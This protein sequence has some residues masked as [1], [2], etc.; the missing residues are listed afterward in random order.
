M[1]I[2]EVARLA[3]TSVATVSRVFNN[4]E[5]VNPQTRASVQRVARE[6]GYVPNSSARTLRTRRSQ[7]LGVMLP[8]LSN[9]VFAEC[10]Q[11]IAAEAEQ[12][13]YAIV[14][15]T[16]EYDQE[17]ETAAAERLLSAG[18]EALVLVVSNPATSQTLQRT[19]QVGLPYVLAYSQTEEHAC[20]SVDNRQAIYHLVERLHDSGHQRIGMVTGQ[21]HA[22]DRAQ[23]RYKGYLQGMQ[24]RG[25]TA[26]PVWEL[27]FTTQALEQ[28]QQDL[29]QA[30]PPTAL[31][32]SNDLI[33]IR[34]LR[35]AALAGLRVPQDLCVVG[36]DGIA[37][38]SDLTPSLASIT[39]P[40]E[41]IGR[42]CV[43]LLCDALARNA[44][45]CGNDSVHLP[46]GWRAGESCTPLS[47][48][49][50]S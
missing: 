47:S 23:Q 11:G 21:L 10:L 33:A 17:R 44:L 49:A 15:T 32:C 3:G 7:V 31:V 9:P 40:N 18:V 25:L 8:T 34:S 42:Q 50:F 46:Y 1:S 20:V 14:L 5:I 28:L 24:A 30:D 2:T 4:P 29:M 22:S 19:R 38:G 16:T 13:G 43:A 26:L 27:P 45:L 12:R 37:L 48:T 36:F 6:L 35:A 39:Q 41:A